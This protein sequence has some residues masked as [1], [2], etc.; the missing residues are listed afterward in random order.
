MCAGALSLLG[1]ERVVYGCANDRFGGCGSILDIHIRGCGTC[2]RSPLLPPPLF[3]YVHQLLL[4]CHS[5]ICAKSVSQVAHCLL[6]LIRGFV[7][8]IL[9]DVSLPID[10]LIEQCKLA[11]GFKF[12]VNKRH[13]PFQSVT[14]NRQ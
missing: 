10:Q 1:L 11:A 5:I 6:S 2:S 8:S 12:C 13:T 14:T 7:T 3:Q 9:G 4:P